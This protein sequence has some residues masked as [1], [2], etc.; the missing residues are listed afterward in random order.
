MFSYASYRCLWHVL[1][2]IGKLWGIYLFNFFQGYARFRNAAKLLSNKK[3]H[4]GLHF[5]WSAT[6]SRLTLTHTDW[7][8]DDDR[9]TCQPQ[10]ILKKIHTFKPIN[11]IRFIS[12]HNDIWEERSP[13]LLPAL[14]NK[15]VLF[16]L[17]IRNGQASPVLRA[18]YQRDL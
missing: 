12:C 7:A 17:S 5:S 6:H 16:R 2:C 1:C 15:A 11:R 13:T 18:H 3:L 4:P 8:T 9:V 14:S 10:I